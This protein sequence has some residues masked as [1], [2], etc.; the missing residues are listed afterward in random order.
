MRFSAKRIA[1]IGATGFIG[2]HLVERLIEEGADILA[3]ARTDKRRSNLAALNEGYRLALCDITDQHGVMALFK[4]FKPELVFHLACHP[5]GKE[6]FEQVR[7][8]M[9]VNALGVAN[10]LEAGHASGVS[11]FIL[12]DSVK[13][14]GN[15]GAPATCDSKLEPLC[16]YAIAKSAA[17][18]LCRLYSTMTGISVVG[19]R[20]TF[21]YGPRQNWN[22]VR[23]VADCIRQGGKV[24]LQGGWQTRDPLHISDAV[25]AFLL[26]AISPSA[27]GFSIPVGGGQ[28]MTI[29]DMCHAILRAANAH[30]KIE[31]AAEELRITEI[32][33]SFVDNEDA[34]RLLG[35]SP[36]IPFN[37]GLADLFD[38]DKHVSNTPHIRTAVA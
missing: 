27:Y 7:M 15:F 5:D 19:I 38:Q 35:W 28:E 36:H 32:W 13:V 2:S 25:E 23:Y 4:D 3:V 24:K 33:R 18:H 16:S 9:N 20:P 12:A 21:V 11:V 29:T 10:V 34:R 14:H 6:S 30:N 1:V 31:L 8:S 37:S 17:W 22:L 26:A